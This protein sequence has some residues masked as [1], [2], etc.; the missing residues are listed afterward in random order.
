MGDAVID[1]DD[2]GRDLTLDDDAPELAAFFSGE[3]LSPR[4]ILG[5]D[6]VPGGGKDQHPEHFA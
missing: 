2:V 1:P 3:D 5:V 4:A 6:E